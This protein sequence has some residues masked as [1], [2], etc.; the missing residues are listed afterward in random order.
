MIKNI[1]TLIYIG[2]LT[3]IAFQLTETKRLTERVNYHTTSIAYDTVSQRILLDKVFKD[4]VEE[5]KE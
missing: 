1:T 5:D 4:Y 3:Y 2:L